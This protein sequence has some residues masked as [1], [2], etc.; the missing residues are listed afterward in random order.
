MKLLQID[1]ARYWGLSRQ[2]PKDQHFFRKL[3]VCYK[4]INNAT[5]YGNGLA[6]VWNEVSNHLWGMVVAS[7]HTLSR[8]N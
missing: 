3:K 8:F 1:G 2:F 6:T 7:S 4:T 5:S